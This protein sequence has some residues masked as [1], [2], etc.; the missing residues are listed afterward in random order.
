MSPNVELTIMSSSNGIMLIDSA[1]DA[2]E[3]LPAASVAFAVM[4]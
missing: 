1:E 2:D 3:I 4:L